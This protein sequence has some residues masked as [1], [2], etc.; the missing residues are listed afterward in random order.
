MTNIFF[1]PRALRGLRSAA[2]QDRMRISKIISLLQSGSFP[3]HTKKLEGPLA[4]YRIRI[5][6]W[7]ILLVFVG[8]DIDIADIFMRKNRSDYQRRPFR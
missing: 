2:K 4:G 3:P 8:D 5:G 7:R 1:R 6:R